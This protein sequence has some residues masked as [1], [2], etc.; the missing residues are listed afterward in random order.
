MPRSSCSCGFAELA[1]E[2]ITDHLQYVFELG[3][4]RGTDGNAHFETALLTCSCG[5]A[6]HAP[7]VLD[8][9]F[10][11]IFTPP[12]RIARDGRRHELSGMHC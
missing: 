5:L 1:D 11:A 9:H 3:D 6:T 10:L 8:E 7:A 12:S 2:S 4:D